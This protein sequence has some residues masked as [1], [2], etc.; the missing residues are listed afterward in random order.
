[1]NERPDAPTHLTALSPDAL[2]TGAVISFSDDTLVASG[3]DIVAA[4]EQRVTDAAARAD[5]GDRWLTDAVPILE[6]GAAWIVPLAWSPNDRAMADDRQRELDRRISELWSA[7]RSACWYLHGEQ[8]GID[9]EGIDE[10]RDAY[11]EELVRTGARRADWWAF[12]DSAVVLVVYGEPLPAPVAREA[13]HVLPLDWV[14]PRKKA[15]AKAP[16]MDLAWSWADV[17]GRD[18]AAALREEERNR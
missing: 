5:G 7:I 10:A 3:A 1:M 11:A 14:R 6:R 9:L 15:R 17:V 2:E 4:I 13:V 18:R 8:I 12:G 16:H